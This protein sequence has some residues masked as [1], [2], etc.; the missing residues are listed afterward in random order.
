MDDNLNTFTFTLNP[1]YSELNLYQYSINS[2]TNWQQ[3]S[4]NPITLTD[5]DY[6]IGQIQVRVTENLTPGN[7]NAGEILTN[8]VAYTKGL[9]AGP[10]APSSLELKDNNGLSWDIVSDYSEPKFY[11]YTN[12]KGVTWQQAVSNPQH[13]GHLAYNK[14]DVGIRVKEK[15]NGKSNAAG[16]ILWA[17]SNSDSSYQFEIYPYTWRDQNGDIESLKLSG[18]WDKT[19][20]SCLIDHNAILPTF[21]VSISSV[22]SSNIDEEIT[23]QLIKKSCTITDWKLIDLDELVTLSK[24]EVKSELAD[25][26]YSYNKFITKNNSSEVVFVQ[27]GEKLPTVHSYYSGVMLL[28]WQYP[29][30]TAALSTITSLVSA[31]QT[32]NSDGESGYNL[33]KTPADTLITSYQ[34]ATSISEYLLINN[35]ITTSQT[36]LKTGID[37]I[38]PQKAVNDESLKHA[39]FLAKL[40]KSDPL[41]NENQK[42]IATNSITDTTIAIEI[43]NHR[44]SNLTDLQVQL[45]NITSILLNINSIITAQSELNQLTTSLTNFATSYPALLT[46]LTSAQVGSEQHQQAKLLLD[47]WHQLM[48]KY[49]LATD[50]L[51]AYQSLLDMLPAGFH[52]D[53]LAELTLIHD[54]LISAQTPFTLNQLSADYQAA[55]Q[56]FED[57]YQ[58][59]YKISLDNA[60][61]GTHFAKL[62]IAGHYIEANA[63]FNQGWRCVID[64]RYQDRKRVWALLNKGTIDSIDNVAY[65]G[66]SNKNLTESDGLLAQY[67]SDLICGLK[68]WNTPTINL[69]ES[70]ATTNNSQGELSID[71]S[72]FPNH[73]GNIIDNY[74]YW[75]DQVASNSK[76]YT[77]QY[78][79][80]KSSYSKRSTA[81]IGEDNYITIARLFNQKK[82]L[83]LDA[84]GNETSDWDTA[85]CVKDSSGLIWQLP[86]N[87]DVNIRYNTV[88]K[89]TGVADDGGEETDNIPKL[90]NTAVSP[91]CGKTNWQLPTLAQLTQLYFYPL[92]KTYFQYWN[93]DSSDNNDINN[94]LSRDINSDKNVCLELDGDS[95]YCARKN[96]NGAPQYKYLYMMVSEPTKATPDAPT[97]GVVVDTADN[98][99]FAWNNVT[100]FTSY[101]DYEY[102]INAGTNW[103]DA[104]ANPQNLADL[105]L[106]TGD[107]QVRVT[108]KPLEYLPAGKILQSEQAYTS[109]INCTGYFYNQVCY[110]LVTEQ[111]NHDSATSH[112][113]AEGSELISK[114]ATVDFNLMA[115]ALSLQSGTNYWLK[116]T[117][118][119]SYGYSL[120]DS[121]GWKPDNALK[122][123][124]TNQSFICK[125]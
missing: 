66:G 94:Y 17:S 50:K 80:L 104:T 55:K 39:L 16:D 83:L 92:D 114:D 20:T 73:Q 67:N 12:D 35:D 117:D 24:S 52:A 3:V 60:K 121:S 22:S 84:D 97:N 82:Q 69:L 5:A 105:N 63:S 89:L 85:F 124:S 79:S 125:K 37:V 29:G 109:L 107:V 74:Y 47:E 27:E 108:A 23:N 119:W 25:F 75:S 116:E 120:R 91:L 43:Q 58:S 48:E 38:N 8:N 118:Y 86:K 72:V 2:G 76:H 32:Q 98:N 34:N 115:A 30:A 21:W 112:C 36:S 100:G 57:A 68:D 110:S 56:A 61:I 28:K 78:N 18:D 111:K 53:A 42:Q 26:S 13:I 10:S 7:N 6:V 113:T 62:D 123:P 46:A 31:I 49:L 106:A 122:H 88:A 70:L 81:D 99:S 65:A 51:N 44:I 14:E 33:A 1:K 40:I 71:P 64:L 11:E 90:L 15:A 102:S 96:Y 4:A 41:A 93:I 87:D 101:S 19:E 59:G 45:T 54:N 95:T 77:Y 9:T 103:K